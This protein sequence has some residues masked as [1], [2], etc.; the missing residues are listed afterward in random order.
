MQL[1]PEWLRLFSRSKY[2]FKKQRFSSLA[3][4]SGI[5]KYLAAFVLLWLLLMTSLFDYIKQ[6]V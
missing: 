1:G 2:L 6:N 4:E 3:N 5:S